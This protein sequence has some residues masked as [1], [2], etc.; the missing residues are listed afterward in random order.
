M[1]MVK[2]QVRICQVN[3]SICSPKRFLREFESKLQLWRINFCDL[4][5]KLSKVPETSG[6][7][8]SKGSYVC[9]HLDEKE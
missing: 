3:Q 5:P 1:L 4:K 6:L 7:A 2:V 8:G 9:Q